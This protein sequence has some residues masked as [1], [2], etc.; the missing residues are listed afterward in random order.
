MVFQKSNPFAKSIYENV[1]YSLRISGTRD[2]AT[3]DE[4][5]ERSL[6][7]AAL[8]DEV[9]DRLH[10]SALGLSGGQMR[11]LEIIRVLASGADVLLLDEPTAGVS[12]RMKEEVAQYIQK[13]QTLGKT[14]LVIEHDINFIQR[15]CQRIVVLESG[16]VIVDDTP[17]RVCADERLQEIYFGKRNTAT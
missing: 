16:A 11:L 1:V 14:V 7:G 15:F 8:W 4:A 2:R 17:E 5:A 6:R 13:L 3:L 12:P 10:E 9:K